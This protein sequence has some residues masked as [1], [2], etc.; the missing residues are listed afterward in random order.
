MPQVPRPGPGP[1]G[2]G[3]S[4]PRAH[5]AGGRKLGAVVLGSLLPGPPPARVP[6]PRPGVPVKRMF[7]VDGSNH[8][9]R[10]YFALPPM[11]APDGFPTNALYGF[12][13]LFAKMIRTWEPDYVVVC[14][15]K[16]TPFRNQL[17]PDYKGHR[18]DMPEDLRAQWPFFSELVEGFGFRAITVEGYEA[19]DVI[20]TLATRYAGPDLEV[21]LVT[22][23][24]D[25]Y[26][27]VNEHVTVLDLMKDKE[28]GPDEVREKMGV[29]PDRITDLRGLAG[30]TSDNIP[31][32]PGIGD[33]TAA[34][35][36]DKYDTVE[37]VLEA[38]DSI[39]GKRGENIRKHAEDIVLSKQ[40]ATIFT[41]VPLDESLDTLA[42]RGLQV[43]AL[44]ELFDRWNFGKVA[45][46]LLRTGPVVDTGIYRAITTA[47][48]L[49]ALVGTLR[50]A[51]RFGFDTE[52]DSL[53]PLVAELVGMSF[54]WGPK[55]AVYVP[56]RHT[57]GEQLD[58]AAVLE[59][60]R[61]LI[62]DPDVGKV[63]SN[64]KYDLVV[65]RRAG[66]DMQGI[67]GDTLLLDYVVAAHER[68]HGLDTL[69]NRY[70]SHKMTT[71]QTVS[72][73]QARL[74]GEVPIDEAT[75]YAAED[76]QV[77]LQIHDKLAPMLDEGMRRVYETIELP[78]V[79]IL[80][81]METRGIKLDQERLAEQ[82]AEI[83]LGVGAAEATCH[84]IVGRAF[85]VG[86]V[87]ALR[88]ILFEELGYE[89]QKKTKTGFSTDS[90]VLEKL[91]GRRDP[92]LP[93]AILRWRELTKL[94]STYLDKL[95]TYVHPTDG[96]IHTSFNQA[97]AATGRLSSVDPNLQ[98][99]PVRTEEGRRIREAFVP[100]EGHVFLSC[101]YS[102]V[103][104]RILAH[105]TGS[106]TLQEAFTGGIDIHRRTA[107]EVFGVPLEDVTDALRSAAKA[108]NYGLLY[109]Q[110]A[111]GLA[112]A[113]QISRDE[114]RRYMDEY[115]ARMP[116]VQGWI[117]ETRT[118]AKVDGYV[119]TLY[120]RKRILPQITSKRW[121]L[122]AAAE[123]EAVNT[124]IQGTAADIMKLAMIGVHRRLRAEG[125]QAR[126]LLQ[127]HDEL[128]LE[129]P[130]DEVD[131]VRKLVV[132]EMEGAADLS[133]PLEVNAATGLTW[134]EAH[135]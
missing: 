96:R 58:P 135:G 133:V 76:A 91:V 67:A 124:I 89:P 72:K 84:E 94:K 104:L 20:G 39:K 29:G 3:V 107:S 77:A 103:E 82:A 123:R 36:L 37:G 131:V 121:N 19:D 69:A 126:M 2:P 43:E 120:G 30:D 13:T 128:L 40:L 85:N 117:E 108:V 6:S 93:A 62:E 65:C 109:G 122:R 57:D 70:L 41:E 86:S 18:P 88:E 81:D 66:L 80:A 63:G 31:G 79:P 51:G 105:V 54:S 113:Q 100:D 38:R 101:D 114:A 102:Q 75:H 71:Y 52:T 23:D 130:D 22:G 27:L 47:E 53:D 48:D 74:F 11:H 34:K 26:Q 87:P 125:R 1:V 115:F 73:G 111:F 118:Q 129:V 12:T 68:S 4:I 110:T 98:N 7:L 32:V 42:P 9:F 55:D 49:E 24:R 35:L 33:K 64:L 90:S 10:A 116:E 8:A 14:F 15:D 119:R 50:Q 61:G 106:T 83:G 56:F 95:P 45:R 17:Y 16:G 134:R 46:K 112:A 25:F 78:L 59:A 127:V 92:D 28:F 99:I 5:P 60:V 44:T 97:V 132:E 21:R